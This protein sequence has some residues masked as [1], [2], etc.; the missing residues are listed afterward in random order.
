MKKRGLDLFFIL[1]LLSLQIIAAEHQISPSSFSKEINTVASFTITITN[2]D[3]ESELPLV[4]SNI[5]EVSINLPSSLTFV[6]GTESTDSLSEFTNTSD[7]LKWVNTS[8]VVGSENG[9]SDVK[10]FSFNANAI[11]LGLFD[12]TVSTKN[13]TSTITK[14]TSLTISDATKPEAILRNPS[15]N[16][17]ESDNIVIFECGST[18]NFKLSTIVLYIF[19]NDTV[20]YESN[21]TI[22]GVSNESNWSYTFSE[23]GEYKWNC[24][25]NDS[26]GNADWGPNRTLTIGTVV[27]C[28]TNWSCTSWGVC[29][30]K[31]QS[32][33]CAD[34]NDCND[35]STKPEENQSCCVQNW[36][37]TDWSPE[38]CPKNGEQTRTCEDSMGCDNET[39]KPVEMRT[40]E[41]K[42][43]GGIVIIAVIAGTLI[44]SIIAF[45]IIRKK[46]KNKANQQTPQNA[47]YQG[48]TTYK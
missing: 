40:C 28:I 1:F 7:T 32:R 9:G 17:E 22:N 47:T 34:L 27:S 18:D 43:T 26:S 38:K 37:C 36:G 35:N 44:I 2:T 24:F 25:L 31:I 13:S 48:Y 46:I 20:L 39:N 3:T 29:S 4:A 19:S 30:N 14:N 8:Y 41:Y 33:T 5:T 45:T 11:S 16:A 6:A 42:N 21:Q 12:I 23:E 10:T 15:N